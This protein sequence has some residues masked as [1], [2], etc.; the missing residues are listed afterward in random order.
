LALHRLK[1]KGADF[2]KSFEAKKSIP[3]KKGYGKPGPLYH[4]GFFLSRTNDLSPGRIPDHLPI[5]G[6]S[7]NDFVMDCLFQLKKGVFM[8]NQRASERKSPVL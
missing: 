1:E 3:G 5:Q 6:Q 4:P 2:F 8:I 7:T